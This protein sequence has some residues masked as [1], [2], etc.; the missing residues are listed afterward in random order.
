MP[1]GIP[2]YVRVYDNGGVTADRYTVAYTGNFRREHPDHF[3]REYPYVGMSEHPFHPQGFG[4][5]GSSKDRPCDVNSK[6]WAPA[7]GRTNHLGKRIP[8]GDLPKDCQRLVT[9]GYT[10]I[11][12]L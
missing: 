9:D 8:F 7:I 1:D 6:G 11:W 2:R 5:H 4:Q 12:E 10:A 3:R